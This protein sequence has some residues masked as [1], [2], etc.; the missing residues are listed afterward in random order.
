MDIAGD[1]NMLYGIAR[2]CRN[3]K[4]RMARMAQRIREQGYKVAEAPM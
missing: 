1:C 2:V 3:D 4:K